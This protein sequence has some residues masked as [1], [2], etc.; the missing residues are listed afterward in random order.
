MR[1]LCQKLQ[2]LDYPRQC[3][4]LIKLMLAQPLKELWATLTLNIL[5][6]NS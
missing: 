5:E 1:I 6:G 4:G 3:L 2:I